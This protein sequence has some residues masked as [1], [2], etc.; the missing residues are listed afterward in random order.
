MDKSTAADW[1]EEGGFETQDPCV[2]LVKNTQTKM[3]ENQLESET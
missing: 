2:F 3:Y 1:K